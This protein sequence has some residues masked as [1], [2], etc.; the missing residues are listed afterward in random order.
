MG[1]TVQEGLFSN[2]SSTTVPP[3]KCLWRTVLNS[4]LH[5]SI[6][7]SCLYFMHITSL[8]VG[9]VNGMW[10]F[11]DTPVTCTCQVQEDAFH[12]ILL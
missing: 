10:I 12:I 9:R 4:G 11:S 7:E 6:K 3:Q 2:Q 5:Q 8:A 1:F